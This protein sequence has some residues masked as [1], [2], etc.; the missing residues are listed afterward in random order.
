[1]HKKKLKD[2]YMMLDSP[3]LAECLAVDGVTDS[4]VGSLVRSLEVSVAILQNEDKYSLQ[5]FYMI[6]LLPGGVYDYE[7]KELWKK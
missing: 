6:G 2:L 3:N 5:F 7:L 1:M 4:T